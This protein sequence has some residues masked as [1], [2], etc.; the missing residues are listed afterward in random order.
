MLALPLGAAIILTIWFVLVAEA[1]ARGKFLLVALCLLALWLQT[2]R[3]WVAGIIIEVGISLF[4]LLH[5]KAKM[6]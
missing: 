1:S 6:Q 2:T 5:Q 3:F 4:V